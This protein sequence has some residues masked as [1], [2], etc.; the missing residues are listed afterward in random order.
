M[1]RSPYK[2]QLTKGFFAEF[3]QIAR[4][5]AY[6][7]E[8]GDK[9]RIPPGDYAASLGISASRVANLIS[10]ATAFELIRSVVL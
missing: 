4:L 3:S 9:A 10:L 7:V 8:H 5:L 6:A 1:S 2:L